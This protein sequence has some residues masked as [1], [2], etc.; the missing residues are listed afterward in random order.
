MFTISTPSLSQ[1]MLSTIFFGRV[2]RSPAMILKFILENESQGV[3][4]RYVIEIHDVEQKSRNSLRIT[5]LAS[6]WVSVFRSNKN[7][8]RICHNLYDY[9]LCSGKVLGL[10]IKRPESSV[11]VAGQMSDSSADV[12]ASMQKVLCPALVYGKL[13]SRQA[14]QHLDIF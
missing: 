13:W 3:E 1:L 11:P 12:V 9:K 4:T 8:L 10:C 14:V 2:R 6:T 7:K 5:S